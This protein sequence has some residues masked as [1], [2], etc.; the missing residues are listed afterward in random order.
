[1]ATL[2]KYGDRAWW[3]R[4]RV[5]CPQCN[6]VTQL[7]INDPYTL[8]RKGNLSWR[9]PACHRTVISMDPTE[10]RVPITT[11]ELR[12]A[13]EGVDFDFSAEDDLP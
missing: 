1:M 7:T 3:L 6:S 4:M 10:P 11:P 9:C 12:D 2:W 5:Q 13:Y 8:D